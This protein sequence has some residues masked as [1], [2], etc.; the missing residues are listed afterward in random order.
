M[1]PVWLAWTV[2]RAP[3]PAPAPVAT[4]TLGVTE[5]GVALVC[6]GAAGGS[7]RTRLAEAGRRLGV[8][9]REDAERAGQAATELADYLAGRRRAFDQPVDWRLT[10]GD[11]YEVLRTLYQQVGYGE[12]I[13]Y[14]ELAVRS[15]AYPTERGAGQAARRVGA[16]MG[17]NPIPVI[18]PCHRVLAADGLGGFGGGLPSKTWLLDLEGALPPTLDLEFS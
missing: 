5:A 8:Q 18:V 16:I 6:F 9:P 14:G 3:V 13:T 15:G 4:L 10:H 1:G 17:S 7:V 11:Q 2:V 12:T